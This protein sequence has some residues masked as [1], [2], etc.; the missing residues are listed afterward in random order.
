MPFV[1]EQ[2]PG[3]NQGHAG[4]PFGIRRSPGQPDRPTKVVEYQLG[5]RY[6]ESLQGASDEF[7][8][9]VDGVAEARFGNGLPEVGEVKGNCAPDPTGLLDKTYPVRSRTGVAVNEDDSLR[10]LVRTGL[11][12]PGVNP[13]DRYRTPLEWLGGTGGA[14][15]HR[16]NRAIAAK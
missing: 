11:N 12:K 13:A 9:L 5:I 3:V 2:D 6:S 4:N 8:V 7:G 1:I 10:S 15:T 16:A 14:G